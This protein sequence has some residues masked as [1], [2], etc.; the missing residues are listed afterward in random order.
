M[1]TNEALMVL[2][3]NLTFA[4]GV[5]RQ[6]DDSFGQSGAKI[7]DT[8]NIRK[9]VRYLGRSGPTLSVEDATE[10]QVPLQ[11]GTQFGVDINFTSKDLTLSID[12]FS[13]RFIKPA[14]ATVANKIDLDGLALYK[15]VF[16]AVGT[17]GTVPS[18]FKTFTDAGAKLDY[19]AAPRDGQRSVVI[20]PGAQ[21]AVVDA[22]KGL[23]QSSSEIADQYKSGNMG[24]AAGFKWSMDQNIN[25]HTFGPQGGTPLVNGASQSGASLVTDGW[26]AAAASRLKKGDVFTIAGVYAVNPQS[27]QSTGS[28]QQFVA[29]ADVSSDGSGNATIPISPSIVASGSQQTVSAVPA[30]NAA[31]TVYATASQLTPQHLAYHRDAFVLGC[32]D[33]LLPKGVDMAARVSDKKL[34]MS[35]RMVRAYDIN[36]DAF[37]C[38]LDVLYGWKTVRPE[39]ACRIM[40]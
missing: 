22:L 20:D 35:V 16:Q 30:D 5:N 27:R 19:A 9:P 11:L 14:V 40:G 18:T 29:T 1:I 39:L 15:D 4:K 26:T 25:V 32:A 13:D 8:L 24:L 2:E 36:N 38:R 31:I 28:L 37:P 17:A 33:L 7:G 10:T 12:D 34:G 23:F 6:Y 21:S 3:N